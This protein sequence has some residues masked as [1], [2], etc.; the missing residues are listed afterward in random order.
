MSVDLSTEYLGLKL[1]SPLVAAASP[2]TGDLDGLRQI[3]EAGF[4]AAVMPSL[5]EEQIEAEEM[6]VAKLQD[7]GAESFVEASGFFPPLEDYNIGPQ[8]YL[9]LI[10]QAKKTLKIPIIPSLNGVSTGGW[11]WYAKRFQD[12][13]ADAIEL[14]VYYLATDPGTSCDTV[15]QRYIDLVSSIRSV[16]SIPLAVKIGPQFSSLPNFAKRLR[17]AGADGLVLF[18]RFMQPDIDLET[19]EVR[20][21][22]QLS[23]SSE[24]LL[25]LRWIAILSGRVDLSLAATT[26]VHQRDD[27]LKLLL[28]GANV[29]TMAS[30]LLR[31]GIDH[32]ARVLTAVRT[33]L[34][35]NEYESVRQMQGS[36][37]QRH[38]AD[39]DSFER[40]NYMRAITDFTAP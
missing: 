20:P 38:S 4:G 30:A 15:E 29:A 10:E 27:V 36:L 17:E 16:T 7:H 2:L 12:A 37:S 34:E 21:G 35:E 9:E 24:L 33:W 19:L 5:F 13:G 25:P 14:N 40:A 31:N 18:N 8:K 11:L 28:A 39:P 26:G 22:L 1:R 23:T 3:E 32:G 6:L